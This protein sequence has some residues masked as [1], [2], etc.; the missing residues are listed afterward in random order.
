[1]HA[2]NP[3]EAK[4]MFEKAIVLDDHF[5]Q[6]Y[7]NAAKLLISQQQNDEAESLLT[8]SISLD[9]RD[10]DALA[11]LANLDLSTGRLDDAI[12][13]A[14]KVHSLPHPNLPAAHLIAAIALEKKALYPEAAAEYRQFL[15]EAPT[16]KSA[17]RVRAQLDAI[18][19]RVH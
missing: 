5:S 8:K 7:V 2:N 18:S 17:D 19:K 9:P 11:V 1:M 13:N 15:Q 14:Q 16:S 12:A 3:A 4:A 6:A 10:P